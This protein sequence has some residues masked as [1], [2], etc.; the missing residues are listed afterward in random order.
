MNQET[1][2]W[3]LIEGNLSSRP[4]ESVQ[5][6]RLWRC[7][8]MN[9]TCTPCQTINN[10]NNA[11]SL[12]SHWGQ[13]LVG[14]RKVRSLRLCSHTWLTIV[15]L[16]MLGLGWEMRNVWIRL[17][18]T[19][20][21]SRTAQRLSACL[22]VFEE[23]WVTPMLVSWLLSSDKACL[24]VCYTTWH[25]CKCFSSKLQIAAAT[26]CFIFKLMDRYLRYIPVNF[27]WGQI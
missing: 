21:T 23:C 15:W 13:S 6:A 24:A 18:V 12:Y 10:P 16:G 8:K 5:R 4:G 26:S 25:P 20:M 19:F 1:C 14:L 17:S 11:L 27:L 7:C 9:R 22:K 2:P 3:R